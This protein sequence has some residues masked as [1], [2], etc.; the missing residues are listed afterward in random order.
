MSE[1]KDPLEANF[2]LVMNK[3]NVLQTIRN[4]LTA[5]V[6][7]QIFQLLNFDPIAISVTAMSA[8]KTT[9][10]PKRLPHVIPDTTYIP[11]EYKRSIDK[12]VNTPWMRLPHGELAH[13]IEYLMKTYPNR[14]DFIDAGYGYPV[15]GVDERKPLELVQNKLRFYEQRSEHFT[16][17]DLLFIPFGYPGHIVCLAI[18]FLNKTVEYYDSQGHLSDSWRRQV[19]PAFNMRE[20]L[21]G[22]KK[23]CFDSD[24]EA[25]ILEN[26]VQH[27]WDSNN[28]VVYV[29]DYM[30][31]RIKHEDFDAIS[32]SGKSSSEIL[33]A[34]DMLAIKLVSL[35]S[36][37]L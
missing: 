21:E 17:R 5:L 4:F 18:D 8:V 3:G 19:Y 35:S 15:L 13:F 28:C 29:C 10:L 6:T 9:C 24:S 7:N 30:E 27:Q 11:E 33:V 20:Q 34:R 23:L 22:I 31:R 26:T 36:A 14:F 16:K 2:T 12:I 1:K 37:V 32:R 25:K